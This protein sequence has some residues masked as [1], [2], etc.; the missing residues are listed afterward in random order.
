M[1]QSQIRDIG[2]CGR[3]GPAQAAFTNPEL[4]ELGELSAADVIVDPGELVI[5]EASAR[6]IAAE[7]ELT[8]RKN[9]EILS[10]YSTRE[11]SGKPKQVRLRFLISPVEIR[12][13]A[14]VEEVELVHNELVVDEGGSIRA[15]PTDRRESVPCGLVLRSIGYRGVALAGVPFDESKGTIPNEE[16]RILDPEA[17]EYVVGEYCVGWIKR[18]PTGV[19]GTN[20]KDGQETAE[21]VLEDAREGR[22]LEPIAA[23]RE[24]LEALLAE[25]RPDHVTYEGWQAIDRQES[26]AGERQGRPRVKLCSR[27]ELLAAA[28]GEQNNSGFRLGAKTGSTAGAA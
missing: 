20:K 21:H 14:R 17:G 4:L 2:M 28:R 22:L 12:G 23:A 10:E 13:S 19:I 24:A 8:A 18:G 11:P 6:A 26:A 3:R 5:D 25:R 16:G 15:V 27:E 7:G 9:V 1:G